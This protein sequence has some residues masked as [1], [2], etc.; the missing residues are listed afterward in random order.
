MDIQLS[1]RVVLQLEELAGAQGREIDALLIEAIEEYVRRN[2]H[3]DEFRAQVR[4]AIQD[5]QWL[6]DALAER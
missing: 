1:T 3:E 4:A 5:H 2:T 6:L